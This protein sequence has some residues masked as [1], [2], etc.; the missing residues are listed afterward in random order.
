MSSPFSKSVAFAAGVLLLASCAG[1]GGASGSDEPEAPLGCDAVLSA[2]P[3]LPADGG[4][5]NLMLPDGSLLLNAALDGTPSPVI[6]GTFSL[7]ATDGTC[8]V[9][10]LTEENTAA[11]LG[12]LTG[13]KEAGFMSCGLI[14]VVFP[15]SRIEYYRAD[16]S[17][18]F[19]L[20][21][22]DGKEIYSVSPMFHDER[23]VIMT[24]DGGTGVI[25]TSGRLV[26]APGIYSAIGQ[27]HD[28]LAVAYA[29][30][31]ATD[32]G[33]YAVLDVNGN[34][35]MRLGPGEYPVANRYAGSLLLVAS[36][37]S[38]D[39]AVYNTRGL[40]TARFKLRGTVMNYNEDYI[41]LARGE[42]MGVYRTTDGSQVLPMKY[43]NIYLLPTG[44]FLVSTVQ[45][46]KKHI[47]VV[48]AN[49]EQ[50]C[51]FPSENQYVAPLEDN[52]NDMYSVLYGY[53]SDFELLSFGDGHVNSY[54]YD[55]RLR[56]ARP[57]DYY[58]LAVGIY[59]EPLTS[60]YFDPATAGN[61]LASQISGNA[62]NGVPLH[63][64]LSSIG[65]LGEYFFSPGG[66]EITGMPILDRMAFSLSTTYGFNEPLPDP[67]DGAAGS[68]PV[69]TFAYI[70]A[71]L[72]DAGYFT[73]VKHAAVSALRN[74]GAKLLANNRALTLLATDADTRLILMP[75]R[76]YTGD[77]LK[78]V[79]LM[80]PSETW[81]YARESLMQTA[82]PLFSEIASVQINPLTDKEVTE[83]IPEE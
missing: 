48:N 53:S 73:N 64:P 52:F 67:E 72:P 68:N 12:P 8:T 14:P 36:D 60:D 28:G 15:H 82:H 70:V 58:S 16:G 62:I 27:Y 43:D 40:E 47:A 75:H 17:P 25:D 1:S 9:M 22:V 57:T 66:Y 2:L 20:E 45:G 83:T 81:A 24:S 30:S 69:V 55:G 21:P 18:A 61:A 80:V 35:L 78:L 63:S 65:D 79:A 49:A 13:L 3:V 19:A 37:G 6:D 56:S 41:I 59:D 31:A 32:T 71:S 4:A 11:Q 26:V 42:V 33:T 76:E 51:T 39:K 74:R 38:D 7:V 44:N 23:A 10:T 46:G 29:Y 54:S 34:E 50:I 5:W 77:Q